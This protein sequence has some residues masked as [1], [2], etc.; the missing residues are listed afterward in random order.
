MRTVYLM[1]IEGSSPASDFR[2]L[3]PKR[4]KTKMELMKAIERGDSEDLWIVR[5]NRVTEL[6]SGAR[7]TPRNT[8]ELM[9]WGPVPRPRIEILRNFFSKLIHQQEIRLPTEQLAEVM[10]ARHRCDLFVGGEIDLEGGV[11]LFYRGDFSS[12]LVPLTAFANSGDGVK[13]DFDQFLIDDYGQT[14]KFGDY[15][16]STE[17]ILY[18]F[19]ADYRKRHRKNLIKTEKGLGASIRRLRLQKGLRQTDF[20][21]VD[22]SEKEIRRIEAGEIKKP[23][24]ATLQKIAKKLGVDVEKLGSY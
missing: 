7:F 1:D 3:S 9:V 20:S 6:L 21:S 14:V 11:I 19:D 23:H 4:L 12:V 10:A 17:S 2:A 18:E 13:P 5:T 22:L 16:A 8:P 15:E 24:Q